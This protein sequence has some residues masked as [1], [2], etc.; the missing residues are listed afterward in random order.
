MGL[1]TLNEKEILGL[2]TLK[3]CKTCYPTDTKLLSR[4]DFGNAAR[5]PAPVVR[6]ENVLQPLSEL[7]LRA[8]DLLGVAQELYHNDNNNNNRNNN[9][10]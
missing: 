4:G 6:L 10:Y 7:G 9:R 5:R 8:G 2:C 3:T 1:S